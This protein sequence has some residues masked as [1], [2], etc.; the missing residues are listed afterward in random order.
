MRVLQSRNESRYILSGVHFVITKRFTILVSTDGIKMGILRIENE[1]DT[2]IPSDQ[3]I[4]FTVDCPAVSLIRQAFITITFDGESAS[5]S[6]GA[7][8]SVVCRKID[9]NYPAWRS[10]VPRTPFAKV[11]LSFSYTHLAAF[12]R[13]SKILKPDTS[14]YLHIK[15]HE[16]TDPACPISILIEDCRFY[17]MLMPVKSNTVQVPEWLTKD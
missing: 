3:P 7:G 11:E 12:A 2:N 1:V 9:G 5:F 13:I 15:G 14:P 6:N 10:I 8:G 17:G 4:E 16:T